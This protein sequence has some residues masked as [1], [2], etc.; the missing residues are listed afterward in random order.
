M[1]TI[2]LG[3]IIQSDLKWSKQV[4]SMTKKANSR[5]HM[6]RV[7]KRHG[8][9][10]QD[11]MTIYTS[12][13]RPVTEYAAPV[14]SGALT[15]YDKI[16]IERVQKRA[17]RI[18]MGHEYTTYEDVLS[19]VNLVSLEER[20][21]SLCVSFINKTLKNTI[22]LG[23]SSPLNLRIPGPL[24]LT[25]DDTQSCDVKPIACITVQFFILFAF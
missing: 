25:H 21:V 6:L 2:L 13:V 16:S 7:L 14:W 17:L 1:I 24:E 20:R 19:L 3:I 12:F 23:N 4:Q 15:N 5:I 11:L 10:R 8:L 18:I 9:P 22:Q